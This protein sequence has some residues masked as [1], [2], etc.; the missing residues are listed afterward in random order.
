MW[1]L[2]KEEAW[3]VRETERRPLWPEHTEKGN[4]VGK[5]RGHTRLV[6]RFGL[7]LK[8]NGKPLRC[9]SRGE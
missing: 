3:C 5:V 2:G 8:G 6:L 4:L 7:C 9:L 1:A